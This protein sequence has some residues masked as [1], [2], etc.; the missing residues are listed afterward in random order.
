MGSIDILRYLMVYLS[1]HGAI[2]NQMLLVR[3]KDGFMERVSSTP[4]AMATKQ[5]SGTKHVVHYSFSQA[6]ASNDLS[7]HILCGDMCKRHLVC[8]QMS[9]TS[10]HHR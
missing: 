5:N 10:P 7:M 2:R 4:N 1:R 6:A 3:H 8:G 9:A